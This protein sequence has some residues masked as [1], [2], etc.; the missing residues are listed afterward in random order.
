MFLDTLL[1]PTME[2]TDIW[3][4]LK[5]FLDVLA[6]NI[7]KHWLAKI[8]H[9]RFFREKFS[10]ISPK[11]I[12]QTPCWVRDLAFDFISSIFLL[13]R[14]K[15]EMRKEEWNHGGEF[16]SFL[17]NLQLHFLW[18]FSL[19]L[20]LPVVMILFFSYSTFL[21]FR[22]IFICMYICQMGIQR[23][24]CVVAGNFWN[25]KTYERSFFFYI[26]SCYIF[27]PPSL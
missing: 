18:P 27:H 15:K 10:L 16:S 6:F 8:Y 23:V 25:W 17:D 1:L 5:V 4:I 20:M 26:I 21:F 13:N 3:E 12:N 14:W 24:E 11:N 2:Q 19:L 22:R 7:L 9:L